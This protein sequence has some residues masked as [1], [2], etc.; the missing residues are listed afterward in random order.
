[1]PRARERDA[2]VVVEA[3]GRT[4]QAAHPAAARD[5]HVG[6]VDGSVPQQGEEPAHRVDLEVAEIRRDLD[7]LHGERL[8]QV[9]RRTRVVGHRVDGPAAQIIDFSSARVSA[10]SSRLPM[11]DATNSV[12]PA[13][14]SRPSSL[15]T[16]A[17]SPTIATSAGPAAPS[18]SSMARYDGRNP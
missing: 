6:R 9:E 3:F 15:V 12:A 13:S 2:E 14:A 7:L 4:E 11:I 17:S 10:R 8:E 18:R 5:E 16:V 1:M